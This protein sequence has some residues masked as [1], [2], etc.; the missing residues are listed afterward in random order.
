MHRANQTPRFETSGHRAAAVGANTGIV[1]TG[2][3]ATIDA[4]TAQFAAHTLRPP[5]DVAAPPGTNNLPGPADPYFVGRTE[6]LMRLESALGRAEPGLPLVVCGLGG[7]GKSALALEAAHRQRHHY[8]PVW[9]VTADSPTSVTHALADLATRLAPQHFL[10][11]TTGTERAAWALDWLRAHDDWLLVLDDAGAP[12]DLAAMLGLAT[13]RCVITSRRATGWRRL[14]EPLALNPLPP[15]A[16]AEFLAHAVEPYDPD[17]GADEAEELRRLAD[18]L[19]HLPLALEQ[20]AAYME[21]TAIGPAAYRERLRRHPARMYAMS[22]A[23]SAGGAEMADDADNRRTIDRIW[24]VSLRTITE[25]QPLAGDLLRLLAWLAPD[26]LPRDVLRHLPPELADDPLAV[27][28]A[29]AALHG[30]S[31]ITLTRE[32]V[33]VHGLVQAVARTADPDD[34]LRT[35]EAVAAARLHAVELLVG[36]L[37]ES[38]L[39]NVSGWPRWRELLPH[40]VAFA[41]PARCEEDI[42][43]AGLLLAASLFL[44]GDGAGTAAA[45]YAHRAVDIHTRINGADHPDTLTARSL[46]ASAHRLAGELETAGPLHE[47]LLADCERV[48]GPQH[49]DTL[50]ARANLAYLHALRG[51]PARARDLHRRNLSDLG[52]LHGPDHP[53]TIN[54]RA[55]LAAAHRELGEPEQA[56]PLHEETVAACQR[57]Y[58]PD[59]AETVTAR[60]NLAYALQLAGDPD[61]AIALHERVLADRVRLFGPGHHF[62]ELARDLLARARETYRT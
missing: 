6:P 13:G 15:D 24:R 36:A 53:H 30:Y 2:T 20:A 7:I 26:P 56:V 29:L 32:T 41:D 45:R 35:P 3:Y 16:S 17:N 31:M 40:V 33:T 12:R 37:P 50:V 8:N 42:H 27:D 11:A 21:A 5:A 4:R 51:E 46:L 54:A 38:P 55:N 43:T 14:A 49:A 62:T 60:S 47:L 10:S 52:R 18:E 1:S 44:Q 61:A 34:P 57:V 9:W 22:S 23:V 39:T 59:H 48:L 28:D 25:R 58:G 19:G